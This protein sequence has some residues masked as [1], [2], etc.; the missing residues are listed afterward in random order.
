L[1]DNSLF[2]IAGAERTQRRQSLDLTN[3]TAGDMAEKRELDYL[4]GQ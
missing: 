3:T 1:I 4:N 2:A